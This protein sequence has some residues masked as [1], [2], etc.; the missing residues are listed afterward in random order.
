MRC[1]L[2]SEKFDVED[3]RRV[4]RNDRRV[5]VWPVGKFA[6]D[7]ED[8]A[9]ADMEE[10]DAFIPTGNDSVCPERELK[11]LTTVAGAVELLSRCER[12]GVV[13][14]HPSGPPFA[15]GPAP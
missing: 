7:D 1:L 15:C 13:D 10:R 3:Q 8:G 5:S 4:G 11:R 6:R 12:P 2:Y 14:R 9:I